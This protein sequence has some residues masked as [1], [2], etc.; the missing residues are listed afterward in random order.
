MKVNE[1]GPAETVVGELARSRDP[2]EAEAARGTREK[3]SAEDAARVTIS[4]DARRLQ[5]VVSLAQ[6]GDELR[7]EK[8]R[9]LKAAIEQGTYE[10]PARDAAR[11]IV[12]HELARLLSG[13]APTKNDST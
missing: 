9:R 8:V 6:E 10:V 1:R 11:A 13:G 5:R 4:K 3:G 12:G 2:R 7:S